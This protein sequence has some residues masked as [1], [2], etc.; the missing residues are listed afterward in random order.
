MYT[1]ISLGSKSS[2]YIGERFVDH[3]AF[4][5]VMAWRLIFKHYFKKR[6]VG[7][8]PVSAAFVVVEGCKEL[9]PT[10]H[11]I[12]TVTDDVV[13]VTARVTLLVVI[14]NPVTARLSS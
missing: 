5:N 10:T 14:Q 4:S 8:L 6:N 11:S 13:A 3:L 9:C 7:S 12:P 1:N 2:F